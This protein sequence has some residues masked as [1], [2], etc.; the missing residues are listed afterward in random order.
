MET[1]SL[2][3]DFGGNVDTDA[4]LG[5]VQTNVSINTNCGGVGVVGDNVHLFFDSVISGPEK[6]ELDTLVAGY[7][8]TPSV[9]KLT[10]ADLSY[11]DYETHYIQCSLIGE[12]FIGGTAKDLTGWTVTSG[13]LSGFDPVTGTM[14][15]PEN[16][17]YCFGL[18]AL[19][20]TVGNNNNISI[21]VHDDTIERFVQT[22]ELNSLASAAPGGGCTF[23]AINFFIKDE[24][25]TIEVLFTGNETC[26]F[27]LRIIKLL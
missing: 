5:L 11:E 20:Q 10:V 16:G 2:S 8:Y 17:I 4:L 21:D 26:D 13:T 23:T 7:V 15:F 27:V 12:T 25:E 24:P 3:T 9:D 1:Y 6:T 22:Q 18:T 14:T 19:V